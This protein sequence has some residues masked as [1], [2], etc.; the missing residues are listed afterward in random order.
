MLCPNPECEIN[1]KGGLPDDY[2]GAFCDECGKD[3][4][5][6]VNS[7][8]SEYGKLTMN[9]QF[10][11]GCGQDVEPNGPAA[12]QAAPASAQY[13]PAQPAPVQTA[14]AQPAPVQPAPASRSTE[15][16]SAGAGRLFFRH[17]GEGWTLEITDGDILGRVNGSH[18]ARLGNCKFVS[19]THAQVTRMHDGWYITDQNSKN[20][21][22]VNGQPIQPLAPVRIKQNDTVALADAKFIIT[23]I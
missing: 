22:F 23:E 9:H 11:T 2:C 15:M 1:Q 16:M 18:S 12:G 19:G 4:F 17:T 8:C 21:T 14:P 3:L 6:C 10:C 20:K 7:E 5:R 13:A